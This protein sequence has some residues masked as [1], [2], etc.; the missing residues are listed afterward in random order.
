MRGAH[1]F[2]QQKAQRTMRVFYDPVTSHNK[3]KK[4]TEKVD[5]D[6]R[7]FPNASRDEIE[8]HEGHAFYSVKAVKPAISCLAS[9][10]SLD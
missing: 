2:F 1:W 6:P 4:M 3:V 8:K 5:V 9:F 7:A 10:V